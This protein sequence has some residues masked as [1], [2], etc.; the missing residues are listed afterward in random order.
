M[1]NAP[2]DTPS[3]LD[4]LVVIVNFRTPELTINCLASLVAQ[5]RDVPR[6]RVIVTDNASGDDSIPRIASAIKAGGWELWCTLLPLPRNGGFSYGNNRGIEVGPRARYVL[7]LNSDTIV[8]DGCFRH[9]IDAMDRNQDVG[10]MSCKL[11]NADASVQNCAR[12]F[13]TPWRLA[14]CVIGLPFKFPSLFAH[15]DPE[16]PAWDRATT[17]R[18]VE[19]LGG[20][21]FLLRGELIVRL[22]ALSEDFFFYGEDIE[23]NHRMMRAGYRRFYDPAVSTTHLGGASSDPTRMEKNARSIHHWRG[24]YLVQRKCYGRPAEWLVRSVDVSTH[25][26]RALWYRLRMGADS[27]GFIYHRDVLR[28]ISGPLMRM[29]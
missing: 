17:A 8:H 26:V 24:R 7:L 9:C 3:P 23:I 5:V 6:T 18:D 20:A 16:D 19:W 29:A 1:N 13:P 25:A 28:T 15:D 2:A 22:G 12:K 10:A 21:F 27:P 4:L 11:L 14:S